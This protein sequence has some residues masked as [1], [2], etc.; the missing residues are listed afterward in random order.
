MLIVGSGGFLAN[1]LA[2]AAS[3]DGWQL[4]APPQ[5]MMDIRDREATVD[6]IR[7]WRASVVVNLPARAED[8]RRIIDGSRNLA[9]ATAKAGCRLVQV[10]TDA[11]YGG[12]MAPYT[13]SDAPDPISDVGLWRAE[14][15]EHVLDRHPHPLII[16]SSML[17][18]TDELSEVQHDVRQAC[19]G[20]DD[21]RFFVDEIRC[22]THAGDL[23]AAISTAA[24]WKSTTGV[25]HLAAAEAMSRADFA[26]ATAVWMGYR[27]SLI[28]TTTLFDSGQRRGAHVVLDSSRAAERGLRCRLMSEWL[29]DPG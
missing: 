23:A 22:P 1:H 16:R 25:L 29:D 10:S 27:P 14:A 28:A 20:E 15:E 17:Y 7:G 12:R 11:V 18:G 3:A 6:A 13:E 8:R 5:G 4:V 24:G 21:I 9:I 19:L 26:R 2:R